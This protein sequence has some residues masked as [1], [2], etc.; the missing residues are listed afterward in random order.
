MNLHWLQSQV[1]E[2]HGGHQ[3]DILLVQGDQR[4]A[5]VGHGWVGGEYGAR[6]PYL[7]DPRTVGSSVY[8]IP[9]DA[10]RAIGQGN[11]EK[12]GATHGGV[13]PLSK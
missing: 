7:F 6:L 9:A 4:W 10:A 8:D 11:V 1:V 2:Q 3:P 5:L 13:N 12:G